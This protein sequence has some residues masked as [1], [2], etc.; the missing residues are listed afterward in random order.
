MY[1]GGE[2]APCVVDIW[3]L[4]FTIFVFV[5]QVMVFVK[6]KLTQGKPEGELC[7]DNYALII[8]LT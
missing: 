5:C 3:Y 2:V 8:C 1:G 7:L 4:N 6:E